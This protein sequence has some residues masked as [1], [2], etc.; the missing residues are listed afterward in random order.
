MTTEPN[1][2]NVPLEP[3][4]RLV[5]PALIFAAVVFAFSFAAYIY[6]NTPKPVAMAPQ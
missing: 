1:F 4:G 3:A 5:K 2:E 6:V